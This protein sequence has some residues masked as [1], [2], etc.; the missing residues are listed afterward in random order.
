MLAVNNAF[1]DSKLNFNEDGLEL[2][3][4]SIPEQKI[5]NNNFEQ[6]TKN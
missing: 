1:S 5:S 6:S 3:H 2:E 4:F